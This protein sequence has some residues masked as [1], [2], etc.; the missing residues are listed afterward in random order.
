MSIIKVLVLGNEMVGKTRLLQR[1]CDNEY[2]PANYIPTVGVDFYI[3]SV[4]VD[5]EEYRLQIW[6]TAGQR[7]F[8][9]VI[10][11]Y[12]SGV[13]GI[14]LMFDVTNYE[15][16]RSLNGWLQ[17][18]RSYAR[19]HCQLFLIGNKI[20][21]THY[22][23]QVS[24]EEAGQWAAER[25]MTYFEISAKTGKNVHQL[26]DHVILSMDPHVVTVTP[27]LE[28]QSNLRRSWFSCCS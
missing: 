14:L 24:S 5:K 21:A 4:M 18:I 25:G 2:A 11:A 6:D 28:K 8:R 22:L 12:L 19:P 16:F 27:S 23:R 7:R 20:D 17:E 13:T 1:F 9:T 10:S 3:R 15:S 26:F